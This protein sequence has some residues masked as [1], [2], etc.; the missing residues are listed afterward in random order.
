M[1]IAIITRS[2]NFGRWRTLILIMQVGSRALLVF[3]FLFS[4]GIRL[5][6]KTGHVFVTLCCSQELPPRKIQRYVELPRFLTSSPTNC[7]LTD[8]FINFYYPP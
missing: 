7:L 6:A 5:D 2:A 3:P 4:L 8:V 1:R